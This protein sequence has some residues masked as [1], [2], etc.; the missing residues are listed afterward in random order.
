MTDIV[1]RL[2]SRCGRETMNGAYADGMWEDAWSME[3]AD[4]IERLRAALTNQP[5]APVGPWQPIKTQ[6]SQTMRVL[7]FSPD[8]YH[9]DWDGADYGIRVGYYSKGEWREQG[10]NHDVFEFDNPTHWMPLPAAPH[11]RGSDE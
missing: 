7:L 6:P 11:W 5:S 4:E 9:P 8:H 3:A 10:T 2:R 1:E